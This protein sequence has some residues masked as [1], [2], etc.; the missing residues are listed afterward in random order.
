M[1]ASSL[2]VGS[3]AVASHISCSL[4]GLA[5]AC[6]CDLVYW[7]LFYVAETVIVVFELWFE[8]CNP[9]EGIYYYIL[10]SS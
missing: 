10:F 5:G 2:S 8:G 4:S 7:D 1:F 9:G 6:L 3:L